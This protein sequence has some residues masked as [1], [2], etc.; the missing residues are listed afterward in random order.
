MDC[1]QP[2][3]GELG[4]VAEPGSAAVDVLPARS[5]YSPTTGSTNRLSTR[6]GFFGSWRTES[7]R[8]QRG[9]QPMPRA[10]RETGP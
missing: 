8:P 9:H 2:A 4:G 5:R 7:I 6:L 3:T 10:C 1:M